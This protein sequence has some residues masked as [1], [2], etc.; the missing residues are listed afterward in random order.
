MFLISEFFFQDI[1]ESALR[2]SVNN[3]WNLLDKASSKVAKNAAVVILLASQKFKESIPQFLASKI[4]GDKMRNLLRFRVLWNTRSS[5]W[6][7]VD[8]R[9]VAKSYKLP[10]LEVNISYPNPSIG[11]MTP[12]LRKLFMHLIEIRHF[13]DFRSLVFIAYPIS[14]FIQKRCSRRSLDPLSSGRPTFVG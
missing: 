8:K 1:P 7:L 12:G 14:F 10:R 2:L 4:N 5:I 11:E 9:V 13:S 3:C 6:H